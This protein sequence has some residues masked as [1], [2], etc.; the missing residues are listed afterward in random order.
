MSLVRRAFASPSGRLRRSR[1]PSCKRGRFAASRLQKKAA[2][3]CPPP[4]L[5]ICRGPTSGSELHFAPRADLAGVDV[6]G[7][8]VAQAFVLVRDRH[9]H[10]LGEREG[11]AGVPVSVFQ[12]RIDVLAELG[13]VVAREQRSGSEIVAAPH[14]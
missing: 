9:L 11:Y 12:R 13:L 2:D 8:V 4:T 5:E 6:G 10:A 14:R 3:F 7:G 1:L